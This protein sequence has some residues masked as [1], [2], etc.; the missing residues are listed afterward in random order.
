MIKNVMRKTI[1]SWKQWARNLKMEI[2]AL[3]L[4][5]KDPR[6]PFFAKLFACCLV[7]YAFSPIDLIPDFIPVL[8]YLDELVLLPLGIALALKM[9]P[10]ALLAECRE[11]AQEAMSRKKPMSWIAALGIIGIWAGVAFLAVRLFVP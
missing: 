11:R 2:H 7:A 8:G 10:E 9:I 6:M 1:G 5:C 3:Y 4:A